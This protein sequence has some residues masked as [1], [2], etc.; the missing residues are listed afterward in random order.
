MKLSHEK[1]M[2]MS[3]AYAENSKNNI[4]KVGAVLVSEDNKILCYAWNGEKGEFSWNTLLISKVRALEIKYVACLYV[5]VNTYNSSI[6]RFDLE[7][8]LSALKVHTIYVG[9]P[10]PA[11]TT[12]KKNDPMI[13]LDNV[14]RYPDELQRRILYQNLRVYSDSAQVINNCPY[15]HEK[16]I[17]K[18]VMNFLKDAGLSI[19]TEEINNHKNSRELK[20]YIS[21]QFEMEY[22]EADRLVNEAISS[23]FNEKYGQ[24]KYTT[25]TRSLDTNWRQNFVRVL[26][27]ST[28]QRMENYAI[29][30]VGVGGGYEASCLFASCKN[31]TF[32]DIATDGLRHVKNAIPSAR[33]VNASADNLKDVE[34]DCYD[35][36]ISLR[37]YNSSFFDITKAITEAKRIM[38]SN[39]V[40]IISVA[41]GFL[42]AE[43]RCIIPGLILPGTE[44]VDIYRGMEMTRAIKKEYMQAGFK[45]IKLIP[46]DTEIYLSGIAA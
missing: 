28:A 9:L 14:M 21:V 46:T 36:Y 31:I 30:D 4:L 11:I 37:T 18:L 38:K 42:S 29:I 44:F 23:A 2:N 7:D 41:N 8:V 20:R 45:D 43:R 10:D 1:F 27:M 26:K 35:I 3:I 25:D 19:T 5:T 12:Y 13:T 24:Y 6:N 33:I 32:V 34:N 22:S 40:I 15:F 17:S 16:R 39:A